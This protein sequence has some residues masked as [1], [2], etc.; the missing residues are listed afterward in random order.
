MARDRTVR[1]AWGFSP[2][3]LGL[4]GH[5]DRVRPSDRGMVELRARVI[6]IAI[7]VLSML[8]T[9]VVLNVVGDDD[10]GAEQPAAG[11]VIASESEWAAPTER[12]RFPTAP[13]SPVM[14]APTVPQIAGGLLMAAGSAELIRAHRRD[15]VSVLLER[16]PA[17]T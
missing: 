11:A 4:I 12:L 6:P 14:P 2:P 9:V 16:E 5:H 3:W 1:T 8:A 10:A 13:S 15:R 7:F 17:T